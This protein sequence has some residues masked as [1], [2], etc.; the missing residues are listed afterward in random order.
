MKTE[1]GRD[2][3]QLTESQP[4]LEFSHIVCC[5][6]P[7]E[8]TDFPKEGQYAFAMLLLP[9][10]PTIAWQSQAKNTK[11]HE[12]PVVDHKYLSDKRDLLMI[13][14]GVRFANEVVMTGEEPK[15]LIK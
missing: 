15:D 3:M 14:K 5:G 10:R 12:N 4:N 9:L 8:H 6:G 13:S 2:P 1:P 7:Q 11:L